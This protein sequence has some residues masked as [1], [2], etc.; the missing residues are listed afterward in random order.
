MFAIQAVNGSTSRFAFAS[1]TDR[2]VL[3]TATNWGPGGFFTEGQTHAYHMTV[4]PGTGNIYVTAFRLTEPSEESNSPGGASANHYAQRAFIVKFN[5]QGDVLWQREL[6]KDGMKND[7][8]TGNTWRRYSRF[9]SVCINPLTGDVYAVGYT[10]AQYQDGYNWSR[11]S[12]DCLVAKYNSSGTLQYQKFYG[13]DKTDAGI[14]VEWFPLEE[15]YGSC[16]PL[17]DGR[18]VASGPT[19]NHPGSNSYVTSPYI[20]VDFGLGV[21]R[22]HLIVQR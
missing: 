3:T 16:F 22:S 7:P 19:A 18:F 15:Y 13:R 1:S 6:N 14:G 10:S 2:S 20:I 12:G 21:K 8:S 9:D 5:Q 4:E 17:S 11:L